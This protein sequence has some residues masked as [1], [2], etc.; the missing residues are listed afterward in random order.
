MIK[1]QGVQGY[2]DNEV[3]KGV[4]GKVK[5]QERREAGRS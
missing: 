5:V 2:V 3:L 1:V 4:G